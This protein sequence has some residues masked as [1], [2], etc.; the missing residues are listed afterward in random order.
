MYCLLFL[1]MST[2][3]YAA[4]LGSC[5]QC[6]AKTRSF[7]QK[8]SPLIREWMEK[9]QG[10]QPGHIWIP[11]TE[12]RKYL[13]VFDPDKSEKEPESFYKELDKVT[14]VLLDKEQEEQ[15]P[16]A[17]AQWKK[18][19]KRA[20]SE[21]P[22]L[23]DVFD[24]GLRGA[25]LEGEEFRNFINSFT[26]MLKKPFMHLF[27]RPNTVYEFESDSHIKI[28][29]VLF[30][31]GGVNRKTK[32][33]VMFENERIE[34][35][36]YGGEFNLRSKSG[37]QVR[38]D[39]G[40]YRLDFRG[41]LKS[42]QNS[43][44]QLSPGGANLV[45]F[46]QRMDHTNMQELKGEK[47]VYTGKRRGMK[48]DRVHLNMHAEVVDVK[49]HEGEVV[50]EVDYRLKE[51][52]FERGDSLNLWGEG[53]ILIGYDGVYRQLNSRVQFQAKMMGIGLLKGRN[54]DEIRFVERRS[55]EEF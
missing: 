41:K 28:S 20:T 13:F 2:F 29:K 45:S 25:M 51:K 17:L 16:L 34:A 11:K 10:E 44:S 15:R 48:S 36:G 21:V 1:L 26:M 54:L 37:E 49:I 38:V 24:E 32:S 19:M 12:L 53:K 33:R 47:V 40:R 9:V 31:F 5:V 22:A 50:L 39:A 18:L 23:R 3:G 27:L 8:K 6:H 4:D 52:E 7:L 35:A 46:L 55:Y 42:F 30:L 43:S 14:Q